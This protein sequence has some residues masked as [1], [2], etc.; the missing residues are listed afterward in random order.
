ML[1]YCSTKNNAR[2]TLEESFWTVRDPRQVLRA[3]RSL[4]FVTDS[5]PNINH[6]KMTSS[7]FETALH[8][9]STPNVTHACEMIYDRLAER[10]V[11]T[12]RPSSRAH[13]TT[14][15][16]SVARTEK[17]VLDQIAGVL[18]FNEELVARILFNAGQHTARRLNPAVDRAIQ[19][20]VDRAVGKVSQGSSFKVA[21]E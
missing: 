12:R 10:P 21:V 5:A 9:F 8:Q 6:S 16:S 18:M 17:S 19:T 7:N 3:G 1:V 13:H 15:A 20:V 2:K 11:S 14:S 4:G